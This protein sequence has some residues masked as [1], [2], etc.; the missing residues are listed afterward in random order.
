MPKQE[1]SRLNNLITTAANELT[2][3]FENALDTTIS[4]GLPDSIRYQWIKSAAGQLTTQYLNKPDQKINPEDDA[5]K[6]QLNS[7][8]ETLKSSNHPLS[9]FVRPKDKQQLIDILESKN[10]EAYQ[11][12]QVAAQQSR[13]IRQQKPVNSRTTA[14]TLLD[15]APD[16]QKFGA[17]QPDLENILKHLRN[18]PSVINSPTKNQLE[19]AVQNLPEHAKALNL[20]PTQAEQISQELL[21]QLD[22]IH[23]YV[24]SATDPLPQSTPFTPYSPTINPKTIRQARSL[25][26][27]PLALAYAKSGFS[28]DDSLLSKDLQAE[29]SQIKTY[30]ADPLN[31]QNK[32]SISGY[33]TA[34]LLKPQVQ[35]SET[36]YHPIY[37][38]IEDLKTKTNQTFLKPF[39]T[40]KTIQDQYQILKNQKSLGWLIAP[41]MRARLTIDNLKV[42]SKRWLHF[43]M[44]KNQKRRRL[45]RKINKPLNSIKT[46]WSNWSP[47]GI[48]SRVKS[49]VGGWIKSKLISGTAK[50]GQWFIKKGAV[51]LGSALAKTAISFAE[52]AS[53]IGIVFLI[54]QTAFSLGLGF[55]KR[56]KE[57]IKKDKQ[58]FD[59]AGLGAKAI[60]ALITG[61]KL[62]FAAAFGTVWGLIGGLTSA[63]VTFL[64][65]SSFATPIIGFLAAIPAFFIGGGFFGSLGALLG[66]N[67]PGIAT[68]VGTAISGFFSSLSGASAATWAGSVAAVGIG[69]PVVSIAVINYQQQQILNSA[70]F[71]P[72]D[73]FHQGPSNPQSYKCDQAN[74]PIPTPKNI[75]YSNDGQYAF[76]VPPIHS[77]GCT[78]WGETNTAVD[79][80]VAT[81]ANDQIVAN[82]VVAYTSGIITHVEYDHEYAG[83]NLSIRGNDGRTYYYSHNCALY[84]NAS[85]SVTVGQVIATTDKTGVN[86]EV[87]PEHLHFEIYQ[88][89]QPICAQTDFEEKFHLNKCS[90]AEQC[91]PIS[92]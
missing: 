24:V 70:F 42:S 80:F 77:Y 71:L 29:V 31:P 7:V 28:A 14:K 90:P 75:V 62:L 88:N 61:V 82:P 46:F 32:L 85:D 44:I 76:P 68:A 69:V 59:T 17:T 45:Y 55:L 51:K 83:I 8:I 66:W 11:E 89:G 18:Q 57:K 27:S 74:A 10:L 81:S 49:S 38:K 4:Q 33:L 19:Q 67:I 30:L 16:I 54:F 23:H 20:T 5:V 52:A 86:A 64:V 22:Q 37:K 3:K 36:I 53:G 34:T 92:L 60:Q 9:S 2:Q 50:L 65:V 41:R 48:T 35:L 39:T 40:Y 78:H 26:V 56:L 87:T 73:S 91:A 13:Q 15:Q 21:P 47:K 79:I 6:Q 63:I 43:Q 1:T 12:A 25:N 58:T 84:V 72:E